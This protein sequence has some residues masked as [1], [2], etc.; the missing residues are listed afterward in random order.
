M[1]DPRGS[2]RALGDRIVRT[3]I[4]PLPPGDFLLDP[5]ARAL[6]AQRKL[7]DFELAGPLSI[8][9]PRLPFVSAP[10]EWSDL[11]LSD[12]ATLTLD[13]AEDVR[14][15]RVELK[16]ASAWNVIFD[17]CRPL[18]CDHLSFQTIRDQR[19]WAFGQF[20]RHFVLP[21]AVSRWRK[22]PACE[23]FRVAFDGVAPERARA[24]LGWRRFATRHWPLLGRG[25]VAAGA[26]VQRPTVGDATYHAR[27]FEFLRWQLRGVQP[28]RNRTS[29]WLDY[30]HERH[31]YTDA[32][33][34]E[35]ATAVGAWL[36][37]LRPAWVLDLGCNTGEFTRLA[38]G[39]G[40]SVVAIDGDDAC[41]ESLYRAQRDRADIHPVV[42][43]IDDL[44][45][46]RGWLGVERPGLIERL[47]DRCDVVLA[48]GLIHHLTIGCAIPIDQ[49]ARLLHVVSRRHVIVECLDADDPK[50]LQLCRQHQRDPSEFTIA[51]LEAGLA[52]LFEVRQEQPLAG[53]KR[54]LLLLEKRAH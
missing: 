42:A 19:W 13:I 38:S 20:V 14:A 35:K 51:R 54:T 16:D 26:P 17:G 40:A 5:A 25:S 9:S 12:A 52:P 7:V 23:S 49:V 36:E 8:T 28:A 3:L 22:I 34:G 50:V 15:R 48:L 11:Q 4:E 41:I 44:V 32:A 46:G 53:T 45:A 1:R 33:L 18:F 6:V 21:L 10:D 29:T 43:R 47:T 24:L 31:H 30:E 37:R 2:V 27:L 39:V